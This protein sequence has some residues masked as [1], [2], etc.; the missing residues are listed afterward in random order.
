MAK[1][2]K[3]SFFLPQL[4]RT[5]KVHPQ[6]S[7]NYN[8]KFSSV[9]NDGTA[10]LCITVEDNSVGIS[11]EEKLQLFEPFQQTLRLTGGAG[12]GLHILSKRVQA[13]N[14]KFGVSNRRDGRPGSKFWFTIPYIPDETYIE[15]EKVGDTMER[16][17]RSLS[18]SVRLDNLF[19]GKKSPLTALVVE[20][21]VVVAKTTARMLTKAGYV[22]DMAENG[23]IGLEKMINK[24]Y[25]IVIMDLQMP[26][27]GGL[28]ATRR[29]RSF[30]NEASYVTSNK[31]KQFIIGASA[32][33]AENV[34][35]EALDSGM[36]EFF[37]KPFSI[38]DLI[39]CQ[40]KATSIGDDLV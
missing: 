15:E 2:A 8:N 39:D 16:S 5:V 9:C 21:S 20:D 7:T 10:Y 4:S 33:G 35:L 34:M 22:V 26:V 25:S 1:D 32:N 24:V 6:N 12:L 29:L 23:A 28:E 3:P 27:M 36:N 31:P 37:A 14:G 40:L 18:V 19:E 17:M 30:E 13:L 38:T 11:E